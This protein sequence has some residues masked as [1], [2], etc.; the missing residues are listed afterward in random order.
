MHSESG[1]PYWVTPQKHKHHVG[2]GH[3]QHELTFFKQGTMQIPGSGYEESLLLCLENDKPETNLN[4]L[5]NGNSLCKPHGTLD[6][7]MLV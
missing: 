2:S 1:V 5:W 4:I 3:Q 6:W 7:K